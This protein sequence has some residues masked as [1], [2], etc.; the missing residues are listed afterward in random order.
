MIS[1]VAF[2]HLWC[3]CCGMIWDI[4][5]SQVLCPYLFKNKKQWYSQQ[6]IDHCHILLPIYM[7]CLKHIPE[8]LCWFVRYYQEAFA[9]GWSLYSFVPRHS[10]NQMLSLW[11]EWLVSSR[12]GRSMNFKGNITSFTCHSVYLE[13]TKQANNFA[14]EE[15]NVFIASSSS[16]RW[17]MVNGRHLSDRR[18]RLTNQG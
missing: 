17:S 16:L 18:N 14:S 7:Q 9:T 1:H 13:W 3:T 10:K 8:S 5:L 12:S 6:L 2:A 4:D 11:Q 15:L